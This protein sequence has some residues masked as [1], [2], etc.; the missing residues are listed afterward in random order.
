VDGTAKYPTACALRFSRP[1]G[2]FIRHLPAG[3]VSCRIRSW[4]CALQS[5]APLTKPYAVSGA[6]CP[7]DVGRTRSPTRGSSSRRRRSA[8]EKTSGGRTKPTPKRKKRPTRRERSSLH[9][10]GTKHPSA[11]APGSQRR[12]DDNPKPAPNRSEHHGTEAPKRLQR[13]STRPP[14]RRS[15]RKTG[16]AA[17]EDP[18]NL[19]AFKALLLARIRH[20]ETAV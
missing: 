11:R 14:D 2:A 4:G 17:L 5:F 16:G 8:T 9:R 20:S 18:E 6:A 7:H 13:V 12:N 15:G 19:L 3:L 1:L 10:S